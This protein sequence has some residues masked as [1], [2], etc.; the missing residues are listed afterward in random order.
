MHISAPRLTV[1]MDQRLAA[2][3]RAG[4]ARYALELGAALDALPG[5]ELVPLRHIRDLDAPPGAQRLRTPPHHRL[6]EW[7]ISAEILAR[8]IPAD[9]YH[10]TDFIA[11]RLLR[12][13]IVAT[14]HDLAFLRRPELLTGD[15][16]AYYGRIRRRTGAPRRW[17]TPSDWTRQEMRDQLGVDPGLV[18]VIAHGV[19][20][21]IGRE[22]PLPR[23]RRRN[24]ILALGTVEPRK[25][26]DLLLDA[27]EAADVP[28]TLCVAGQAGWKTGALRRRLAESPMVTWFPSASD[29]DARLLLREA[30]ALAVP[31]IDEG[32]GLTA[33]E[34][35]A[36][37]TPVISSGRGALPEVTGPA[38]LQPASDDIAGWA[39]AIERI[40]SD[41][42]LWDTLST[43][44]LERSR[45]FTWE[46]AARATLD[47]YRAAAF[48]A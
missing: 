31:S 11:P 13:P 28:H 6:E 14:V 45:D 29:E 9:V 8:R 17:I 25:R 5:M 38:A 46:R 33:L 19:P 35:M 43:T 2:Y 34:A 20:S 3:R 27:L 48:D 18:S 44:G 26:L 22:A 32:F 12:T 15:A 36:C 30:T 23:E 47:V 41:R 39:A 42:A 40:I 16:L 10:A 1:A 4:I 24:F 7:L 21:F 37:G